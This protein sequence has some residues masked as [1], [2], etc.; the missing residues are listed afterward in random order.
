MEA[1]PMKVVRKLFAW[2]E[3][4][5]NTWLSR[6]GEEN[7]PPHHEYDSIHDDDPLIRH[8]DLVGDERGDWDDRHL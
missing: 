4:R 6:V 3:V 7:R 2:F 8:S 5:F 1:N